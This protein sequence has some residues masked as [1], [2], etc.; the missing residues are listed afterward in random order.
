[1]IYALGSSPGG[2]GEFSCAELYGRGQA[3]SGQ[4]L[5]GAERKVR[6]P[7]PVWPW[8]KLLQVFWRKG[9]QW[10]EGGCR[11]DEGLQVKSYLVCLYL[12]FWL[13]EHLQWPCFLSG[14]P[15]PCPFDKRNALLLR[16]SLQSSFCLLTAGWPLLSVSIPLLW[17]SLV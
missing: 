11:K 17:P 15:G 6:V 7:G 13:S 8:A 9:T 2:S 1:M 12:S 4:S 10:G 14:H 3:A 16:G 5:Q